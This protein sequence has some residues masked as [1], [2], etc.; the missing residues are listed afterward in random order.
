MSSPVL[1]TCHV[2][3]LGRRN[4]HHSR[5][6]SSSTCSLVFAPQGS[7]QENFLLGFRAAHWG[8]PRY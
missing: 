7:R 3:G 4:V 2:Q 1:A 6:L 8:L 5:K